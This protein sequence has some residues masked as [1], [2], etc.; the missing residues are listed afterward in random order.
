MD[1]PERLRLRLQLT[2]RPPTPMQKFGL[3]VS[4]GHKRELYALRAAGSRRRKPPFAELV[5]LRL[6][7]QPFE[8]KLSVLDRNL[9]AVRLSIINAD[10]LGHLRFG[11]R[12]RFGPAFDFGFE[13]K[14]QLHR[15]LCS[16]T[17]TPAA[18]IDQDDDGEAVIWRHPDQR[19]VA[20]S[21]A[22]VLYYAHA[23]VFAHYQSVAVLALRTGNIGVG[24][25]KWSDQR[26]RQDL[27]TFNLAAVHKSDDEP[28][29]II[30]AR[31]DRTGGPVPCVVSKRANHS[32][33]VT[34]GNVV[35]LRKRQGHRHCR[36]QRRTI[37]RDRFEN[38]FVQRICVWFFTYRFNK[39]HFSSYAR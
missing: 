36:T 32:R 26:R 38:A 17:Q 1:A 35:P 8:K 16:L 6:A 21:R 14:H 28:R 37:H 30:D 22:T 20:A 5:D 11:H 7:T 19:S 24:R 10:I 33:F 2:E 13:R 3:A 31:K 25:R 29:Q 12:N 39:I 15:L 34:P 4:A 27:R 18:A 9:Y 23:A